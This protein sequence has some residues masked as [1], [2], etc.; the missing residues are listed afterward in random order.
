MNS[1]VASMEIER[2]NRKA[3]LLSGL[4]I[5][6]KKCNKPSWLDSI[7]VKVWEILDSEV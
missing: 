4:A 7:R 6:R 2:R 1:E 3:H 5:E